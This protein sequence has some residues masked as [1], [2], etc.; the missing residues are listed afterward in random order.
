VTALL[1]CNQLVVVYRTSSTEVIALQG[2]ELSVQAGEMV[3]VIGT[4]GSGKS[5]LL[6]VIS[7]LAPPTGGSIIFDDLDLG[8]ASRPEL[9]RYRRRDVGFVWQDSSLNL[10]PYLTAHANVALPL[11]T[12]GEPQ[13]RARALQILTRVGLADRV[14]HLPAEL[15]GG[16]QQRVA[17]AVALVHQP[18]LLLADEPTGELDQATTRQVF[19]LMREIGRETG[20][21]QVIVSHDPNLAHYVDRVVSIRDGRVTTEQR[22]TTS[23]SGDREI[24][25]VTVLDSAGR[26]QLTDEQRALVGVSGRVRIEIVDHTLQGRADDR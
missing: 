21:T 3:G 25:E 14:D 6:K 11:A 23:A 10:V 2:L 19:A 7:G 12:A 17:L 8:R 15:S 5:T 20:L 18:R 9:D 4:S 26:L 1:N 13:A 22:V 24:N 16:E